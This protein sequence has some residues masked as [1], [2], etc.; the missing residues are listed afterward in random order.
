VA[1][2]TGLNGTK[3]KKRIV[4]SRFSSRN[5]YRIDVGV[6]FRIN[7]LIFESGDSGSFIQ[8]LGRLDRHDGQSDDQPFLNFTAH[9][10]TVSTSWS[11]DYFLANILL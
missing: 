6:D 10:L 2:N 7:F 4:T 5:Q 11:S 8:R 9:A 3:T 1:E